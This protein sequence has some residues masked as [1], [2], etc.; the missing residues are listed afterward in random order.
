MIN[1]VKGDATYPQGDGCK[2]IINNRA[3]YPAKITIFC[4]TFYWK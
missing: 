3:N 2:I 1:Y 4:N